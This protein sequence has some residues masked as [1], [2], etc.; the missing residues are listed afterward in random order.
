M[1]LTCKSKKLAHTEGH[2]KRACNRLLAAGHENLFDYE[3]VELMLFLIL[4]RKD[5]K[6]LAKDLINKFR[7]INGV[8]GASINQLLEINGIGEGVAMAIKI[9]DGIVKSSISTKMIKHNPI[10]CFE[11]V[12]SYCKINMKHL[13]S[14]EVRIIFLNDLNNIISDEILQC[15]NIDSVE[16]SPREI[17][18]RCIESG[19]RGIILVHNHPGGD[20]TPSP[21]DIYATKKIQEALNII[22]V[23]IFDHIIIGGNRHISFRALSLLC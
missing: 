3:I 5:V 18:K 20:P 13:T 11:D 7:S 2:R 15:G 23:S 19:A 4:K 1:V 22:D 17:M 21:N 10:E 14:E 9:V 8:L 6:P 12:L 16:I